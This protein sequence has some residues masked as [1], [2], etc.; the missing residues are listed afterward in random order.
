MPLAMHTFAAVSESPTASS[1]VTHYH[2]IERGGFRVSKAG[3]AE[4]D[5][6]ATINSLDVDALVS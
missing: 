2:I 6:I 1:L 3:L 5:W 4:I